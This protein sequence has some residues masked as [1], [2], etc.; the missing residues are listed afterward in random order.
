MPER[1]R[2]AL[3]SQHVVWW[4]RGQQT[5]TL[6]A[7]SCRVLPKAA[8]KEEGFATEVKICLDA[9]ASNTLWHNCKRGLYPRV[10]RWFSHEWIM[11]ELVLLQWKCFNVRGSS[12]L[13]KNKDFNFNSVSQ[14]NS[15]V[16]SA[17]G[18]NPSRFNR[19][20][21]GGSVTLIKMRHAS[22]AAMLASWPENSRSSC[23]RA[24]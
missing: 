7:K 4:S 2:R 13:T 5:K 14:H 22:H 6:T 18:D 11:G 20:G 3:N 15:R 10:T 17:A 23:S 24:Q 12:V 19:A 8:E 21:H 16:R 1:L 9:A